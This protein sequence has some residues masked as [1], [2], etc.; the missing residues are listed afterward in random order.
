MRNTDFDNSDEDS[1]TRREEGRFLGAAA[2]PM[3]PSLLAVIHSEKESIDSLPVLCRRQPK[4]SSWTRGR[5]SSH[6]HE[7]GCLCIKQT[8]ASN[9]QRKEGNTNQH[10]EASFSFAAGFMVM[11]SA[12]SPHSKLQGAPRMKCTLFM[13]SK[14]APDTLLVRQEDSSIN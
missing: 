2:Q 14:S 4:H 13:R 8:A 3:Q 5:W 11:L 6:L 7:G 12:D 1:L 9:T 10:L